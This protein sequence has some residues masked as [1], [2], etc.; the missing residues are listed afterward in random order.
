MLAREGQDIIRRQTMSNRQFHQED[1]PLVFAVDTSSACASFAIAHGEEII[2]SIKTEAPVPHSKTF[3]NLASSL[4]QTAGKALPEID[5]FAAAT[6][7]GSFTGL[8]VGLSAIKGLSHA[9][10]KPAIGVTSIDA[11]ALASKSVGKVLVLI[12]AGRNEVYA[13][14]RLFSPDKVCEPIGQDWVGPISALAEA[15]SEFIQDEVPV[16]VRVGFD[17][18]EAFPSSMFHWQVA[19]VTAST[20]EEIAVRAAKKLMTQ[21]GFA[22]QAHYIRPSDAENKRK[23]RE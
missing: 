8:R 18:E 19:N 20:A 13:G 23:D 15:Y 17:C 6:G 14:L 1:S 3:F 21:H 11:I 5:A 16:V 2:A 7:P 4:L 12:N 22:L 10:G 9:L